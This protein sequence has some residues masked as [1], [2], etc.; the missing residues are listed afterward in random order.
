MLVAN[1][2]NPKESFLFCF[3]MGVDIFWYY[4][5]R[6]IIYSL[7]HTFF[8]FFQAFEYIRLLVD[9]NRDV[10]RAT[11]DTMTSLVIAVG[12]ELL[13]CTVDISVLSIFV[14]FFFVFCIWYLFTDINLFYCIHQAY[15]IWSTAK[16]LP[17]F[18]QFLI[19]YYCSCCWWLRNL[20]GLIR[21]QFIFVNYWYV[22]F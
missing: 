13:S 14:L 18:I 3:T 21:Q 10:R 11:H 15:C 5:S 7:E 9:Y 22:P 1:A 6:N 19:Y 2:I 16:W 8:S 4:R 20:W 12:A 17:L